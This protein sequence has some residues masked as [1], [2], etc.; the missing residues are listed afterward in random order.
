MQPFICRKDKKTWTTSI[1]YLPTYNDVSVINTSV[2]VIK[3]QVLL[4]RSASWNYLASRHYIVA[5]AIIPIDTRH[6]IYCCIIWV[7]AFKSWMSHTRRESCIGLCVPAKIK[8]L[9]VEYLKIL[10]ASIGL[11]WN[12]TI[13]KK[14][15]C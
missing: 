3:I 13:M 6:K 5:C 4:H 10:M 15:S 9:I 8:I 1:S 14:Y 12:T 11:R 7:N 2:N